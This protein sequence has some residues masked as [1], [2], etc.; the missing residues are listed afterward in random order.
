MKGKEAKTDA[1]F[2]QRK[3]G[4][5]RKAN[6]ENDLNLAAQFS[7]QVVLPAGSDEAFPKRSCASHWIV[8]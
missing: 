1:M 6:L 5:R 4:S 8:F 3:G 7:K 2:S